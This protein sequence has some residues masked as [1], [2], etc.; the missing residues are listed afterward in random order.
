MDVGAGAAVASAVTDGELSAVA[1]AV[2]STLRALRWLGL[3]ERPARAAVPLSGC[4]C[5][6]CGCISNCAE[7]VEVSGGLVVM[8]RSRC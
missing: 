5:G 6:A 2:A 1:A 8:L 4:A 7:L 3:R